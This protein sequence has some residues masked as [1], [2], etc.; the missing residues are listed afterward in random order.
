MKVLIIGS[1]GR[2][3]ALGW[4]LA[5]SPQQPELY[6]APGNPGMADL[7]QLLEIDVT[8][9]QGLTLYAEREQIDL[10]VVGPELPLSLGIVDTFQ[11]AGLAIFGPTQAGAKIEASKAYAKAIMTQAHVPTGGYKH[12]T[13]KKMALSTLQGFNPPYVIKEDGLAAGKGVTISATLDEAETAIQNAFD[14]GT[15]VVI[16]EFL[17]GQE[18]SVLA[19][20][21]G[22]YAIPM[23]AAQDFKKAL[24]G[25]AGP[26]TGGMGAYAPVPFVTPALIDTIQHTVLTPT[27]KA[28]RK[29]GIEYCG[30]LYAGL[31]ITPQ[32]I[33]KVIEFNSR[34]GD[35]ETQVVLP[36]LKE[37]L[38]D[39]L[40]AS[41]KGDLSAY[42]ESGFRFRSS[43][44]VTVALTSKG[45][46]GNYEKNIPITLPETL[47]KNTLLFHAGTGITMDR[48]L[49]TKGG[50]VL[51]ATGLGNTLLEARERAYTLA[52]TVAF[53]S[54]TYRKDIAQS[55]K[56][57]STMLPL[58]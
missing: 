4:T 34:F 36:L 41:A 9:I 44:A 24:D 37:D 18:L 28:L 26:N 39:I 29:N 14:K 1:G 17:S 42:A 52:D 35:P 40:L 23:L 25:N 32:G 45:Y 10:T 21:D 27:L 43:H 7:G 2:E 31:M 11:A 58:G 30:V 15:T 22:Q 8:D 53:T 57:T 55:S 33:P 19:I 13:D 49:V 16:E 56:I 38:L 54:K 5:N 6:F 50:R 20:C 12:C 48:T 46:P 51:N 47:P 3:H